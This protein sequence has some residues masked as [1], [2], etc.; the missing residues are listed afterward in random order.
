MKLVL[1]ALAPRCHKQVSVAPHLSSTAALQP[2]RVN[3]Y[4]RV[5]WVTFSPGHVGRRVNLKKSGLTRV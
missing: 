3:P 2:C 5:K 4:I 1:Y